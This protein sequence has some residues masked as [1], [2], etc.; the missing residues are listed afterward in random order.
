MVCRRYD[1]TRGEVNAVHDAI[2]QKVLCGA[3]VIGVTTAGVAKH[4]Q[5]FTRLAPKVRLHRV[6]SQWMTS[7][8]QPEVLTLWTGR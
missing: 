4:Q 5:L 6:S 7:S 2:S 3:R 8:V 1:S